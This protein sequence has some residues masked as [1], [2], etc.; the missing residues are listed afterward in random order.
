MTC[1]TCHHPLT[2]DQD[3]EYCLGCTALD[4][5]PAAGTLFVAGFWAAALV[6]SACWWATECQWLV[7]AP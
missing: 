5:A 4:A 1:P 2:H 6:M 3:R 7:M